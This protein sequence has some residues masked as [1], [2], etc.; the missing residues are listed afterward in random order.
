MKRQDTAIRVARD[1]KVGLFRMLSLG[2]EL[3]LFSRLPVV[4]CVSSNET[5]SPLLESTSGKPS[6]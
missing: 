6:L 4:R 5:G 3:L 2:T 1:M